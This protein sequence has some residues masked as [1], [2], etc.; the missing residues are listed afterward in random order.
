MSIYSGNQLY[1][2]LSLVSSDF[3][4]HIVL[5]MTV[6]RDLNHTCSRN[7]IP[8]YTHIPCIFCWGFLFFSEVETNLFFGSHHVLSKRGK[9]SKNGL[10]FWNEKSW[11]CEWI[12]HLRKYVS[13][14]VR[15]AN[16]TLCTFIRCERSEHLLITEHPLV[17]IATGNV[18][19]NSK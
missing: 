12:F 7:L 9:S 15:H 19:K 14:Q 16:V 3:D 18:T 4:I 11:N 13:I 8:P 1:C 6:T 5:T 2:S 10:Y 17:K